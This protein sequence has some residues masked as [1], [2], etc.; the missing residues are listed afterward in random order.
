[1]N[2]ELRTYGDLVL[3]SNAYDCEVDEFAYTYP[4]RV[5]S[6]DW[7]NHEPSNE[8]LQAMFDDLV[9]RR[10]CLYVD[11]R[12]LSKWG[13]P[14]PERLTSQIAEYEERISKLFDQIYL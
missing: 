5:E 12:I 4:E 2:V 13:Y 8:Y 14:E 10:D 1:M 9:E 3:E 7:S 11:R 6:I